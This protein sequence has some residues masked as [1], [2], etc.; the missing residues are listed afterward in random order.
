MPC[1]LIT[2]RTANIKQSIKLAHL[3]QSDFVSITKSQK[4]G[5]TA[6]A[7]NNPTGW[8]VARKEMGKLNGL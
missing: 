6:S 5:R 7:Q 3:E 1:T 2:S 8:S 4:Q